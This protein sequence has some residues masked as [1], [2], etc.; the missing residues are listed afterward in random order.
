VTYREV[1]DPT[2]AGCGALLEREQTYFDADGARVCLRCQR[3]R[4]MDAAGRRIV[5][6]GA[7]DASRMN[8]AYVGARIVIVAALLLAAWLFTVC[9]R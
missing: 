9:S 1:A 3:L 2:C 6:D 8:A 4:E 5:E 7:R